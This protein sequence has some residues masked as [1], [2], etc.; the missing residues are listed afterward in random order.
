MITIGQYVN[1]L[2]SSVRDYIGKTDYL[3][4]FEIDEYMMVFMDGM[5]VCI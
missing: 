5:G 3:G 4:S 2:F 1:L